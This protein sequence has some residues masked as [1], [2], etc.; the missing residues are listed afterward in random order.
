M[1]ELN[2]SRSDMKCRFPVTKAFLSFNTPRHVKQQEN[3][4]HHLCV[5][6][7]R[8]MSRILAMAITQLCQVIVRQMNTNF[9]TLLPFLM[10]TIIHTI[11]QQLSLNAMRAMKWKTS[12]PHGHA[13]LT[14]H[15]VNHLQS[16]SKVRKLYILPSSTNHG[17]STHL[18]VRNTCIA[19]YNKTIH[20]TWRR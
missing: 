4:H 13:S 16:A 1:S 6:K 15:G 8:A 17:V 11:T 19:Y 7:S 10:H 14:D 3:G 18:C 2:I 9:T 12:R 5:L 20:R